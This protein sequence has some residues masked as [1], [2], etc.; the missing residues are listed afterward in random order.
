MMRFICFLL[1]CTIAQVSSQ[2]C[3]GPCHCPEPPP[4]C[5]PGVPLVLDGC[6]CCQMCARQLG[7]TCNKKY[8]CDSQQGLACDYSASYP[9][10]PGECVG[11]EELGCEVN[12]V[13]YQE[14]QRFQPSCA[15]QCHCLGGGVTCLRLCSEEL[16]PPGPDCPHPQLI[17]LPGRCCKQWLCESMEN[18]VLQD[19]LAAYRPD[20]DQLDLSTLNKKIDS[21]CVEQST[22][23]SV[24]SRTCGPGV[25]TRVSNMNRACHLET[26]S[27]FCMVRPCQNPPY[28]ATAGTRWCKP[29]YVIPLPVRLERQGCL[30]VGAFRLTYCSL[31]PDGRCC[32]PHRTRTVPVAFRCPAGHLLHL[33]VM[34]IESCVCHYQCPH[35]Q[36]AHAA[37]PDQLTP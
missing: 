25:S 21:N 17:Q 12:G 14:G 30:S 1:I 13:T 22:E 24:C 2:L 5:P 4:R 6:H 29:S 36:R 23:W 18:T 35:P 16:R 7:E 20:I 31:C 32:T 10:G 8:A 27:R 33:R 37:A 11:Q 28:R 15:V 3:G 9:G 19:A 34:M 26:Q